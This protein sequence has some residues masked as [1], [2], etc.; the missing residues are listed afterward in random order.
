MSESPEKGQSRPPASRKTLRLT[1]PQAVRAVSRA[2]ESLRTGSREITAGPAHVRDAVSIRR[3]AAVYLIALI[4]CLLAGAY[5]TGLQVQ[6]AASAG[7][8]LLDDWPTRLMSGMGMDP[9]SAAT[10]AGAFVHGLLYFL[11]LAV[12]C[13]LAARSVEL[14]FALVRREQLGPGSWVLALVFALILP[15]A[16]PVWQAMLA[17]AFGVVMG[18]EVFG[19]TGRNL[20]HPVLLAWAFLFVTYPETLSGDAIWVPVDGERPAWLHQVSASGS[21]VLADLDWTSAFLGLTPGAFGETSALACFLGAGWLLLARVVSWRVVLGFFAGSILASAGFAAADPGGNPLFG[22]PVHWQ[23]V[24]GGWAFGMAFLVTDPVTGA[25]T[26]P[27]RWVYGLIA[28][29]FV[30]FVRVLNPTQLDGTAI[31][32]LFMNLFAPLIDYWFVAANVRR[33]RARNAAQ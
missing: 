28:G 15:P 3:I 23:I 2:F 4:P 10:S 21:P 1:W 17:M 30:V 26:N 7:L 20:V 6:L 14:I 31:A 32:L 24:L 33:R 19:G 9:V 5:N 18:K 8:P 22:I 11:P 25:H 29:A 13:Y 12:G 27:G 16:T